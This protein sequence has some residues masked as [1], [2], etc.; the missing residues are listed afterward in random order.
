[1]TTEDLN[2]PARR[3][4]AYISSDG[5]CFRRAACVLQSV[6]REIMGIPADVHRGKPLGSRLPHEMAK[7]TLA[8]LLTPDLRTVAR[9]AFDNPDKGQLFANPR[10]DNGL[11]TSQPPAFNLFGL[12]SRDMEL[13]TTGFQTRGRIASGKSPT[14]ASGIPVTAGILNTPAT[15]PPSTSTND[16]LVRAISRTKTG[17]ASVGK[18]SNDALVDAARKTSETGDPMKTSGS[19]SR[20]RDFRE[21]VERRLRMK[22]HCNVVPIGTRIG[23]DA[24]GRRKAPD[25]QHGATPAD[26]FSVA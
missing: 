19:R 18:R 8:N 12:L 7:K 25:R 6:R 5:D 17:A 22:P 26:P 1:M 9:F 23:T 20:N 11:L 3:V 15:C 24:G 4:D 13:A 21:R 16:I 14:S 10:I 2:D